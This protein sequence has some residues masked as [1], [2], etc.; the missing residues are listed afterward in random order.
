MVRWIVNAKFKWWYVIVLE[1][2]T[3]F[4]PSML[5]TGKVKYDRFGKS[6]CEIHSDK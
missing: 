3:E 6:K 1:I 4:N 2:S 5:A